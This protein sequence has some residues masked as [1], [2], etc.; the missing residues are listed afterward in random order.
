[1]VD[2]ILVAMVAFGGVVVVVTA[3]TAM[4]V[5]RILNRRNDNDDDMG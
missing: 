2:N 3:L 5:V 1:M 4:W